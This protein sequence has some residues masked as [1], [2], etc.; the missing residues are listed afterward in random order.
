M[1]IL[2][3]TCSFIWLSQ[4]SRKGLSK[5]ALKLLDQN[6][7]KLFIS[8]ISAFELGKLLEKKKAELPTNLEEWW[9]REIERYDIT[10][11]SMTSLIALRSTRL[12]NIHN[13]PADR[14]IIATAIEH[15]LAI[16]TPDK[17]IQKYPLVKT[18]W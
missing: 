16:L 7:D 12:E 17:L 6:N 3:D 14:I 5:K 10:E 1:K 13:D 9:K 4:K 8:S 2:L 18:L 15:N 11:L